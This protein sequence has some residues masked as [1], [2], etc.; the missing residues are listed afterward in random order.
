MRWYERIFPSIFCSKR[1][2]FFSFL[3]RFICF[4]LFIRFR[5][6]GYFRW[7]RWFYWLENWTH[8]TYIGQLPRPFGQLFA[9]CPFSRQRKH[10]PSFMQIW[11]SAKVS[12]FIRRMP[13]SIGVGPL[14]LRAI[15]S[16]PRLFDGFPT[17]RYAD[18]TLSASRIAVFI[19]VYSLV[20]SSLQM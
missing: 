8:A 5:W 11:R 18:S 15:P 1:W 14:V 9:V 17:R 2:Y 10:L 3:D 7:F 4:R 12:F 16:P 19:E 6:Y 20:Q 13:I